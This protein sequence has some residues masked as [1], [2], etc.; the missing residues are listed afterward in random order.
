VVIIACLAVLAILS[1]VVF[2]PPTRVPQASSVYATRV[3]VDMGKV[4]LAVAGSHPWFGVGLGRFQTASTAFITPE[5][6]AYFPPAALGENAHNNF[7]QILAELGV[8]GLAAF[9]WWIA[10]PLRATWRTARRGRPELV[11]LTTGVS[12]FL[13][14]CLAGHPLLSPPI[15]LSFLLAVGVMYGLAAADSP[16]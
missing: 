9:L 13:L 2:A 11:G 12:A 14:T 16:S 3:R 1:W 5:L 7:L 4:A 10:P 8:S 15:T 6:I